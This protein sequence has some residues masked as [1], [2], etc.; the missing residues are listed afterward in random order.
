MFKK[1]SFV[2]YAHFSGA[3]VEQVPNRVCYFCV[4]YGLPA[5]LAFVQ[6]RGM[7]DGKIDEYKHISEKMSEEDKEKVRGAGCRNCAANRPPV[8]RFH[9]DAAQHIDLSELETQRRR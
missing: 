6:V 4:M 3:I 1:P 2:V 8:G 9:R 5:V 7:I